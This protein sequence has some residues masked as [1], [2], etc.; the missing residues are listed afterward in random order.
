M[1]LKFPFQG[2]TMGS[3]LFSVSLAVGMILLIG[4]SYFYV[5]LPNSALSVLQYP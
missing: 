4:V 3:M 5:Y 2:N 1:K